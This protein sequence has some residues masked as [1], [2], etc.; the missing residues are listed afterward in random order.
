MAWSNSINFDNGILIYK[1]MAL[2]SYAKRPVL[3]Q[4]EAVPSLSFLCDIADP[5]YIRI[6]AA[7]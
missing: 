6:S 1:G 3:S 2:L 5:I 4:V 7:S